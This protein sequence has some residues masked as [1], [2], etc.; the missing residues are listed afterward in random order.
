MLNSPLNRKLRMALIGGGGAGFIGKVHRTAAQL[1][2]RAEL[3]AGAFSSSLER[4]RESALAFGVDPSRAYASWEE[5]LVTEA[6]RPEDKRVDFVS[7]ATPNFLHFPMAQAALAAGFNVICDKPMTTKVADAETLV[8]LVEETGAVFALTHNYTG[9]PMVRQAK[10]M[11]ASGELGEIRAVR[12]NYVQGWMWAVDPE[13]PAARGNWKDD[14]LKNGPGAT[15]GDVGT[16]AYNLARYMTDLQPVEVLGKL[17]TFSGRQLDDYG[18]SLVR[19]SND[20]LIMVTVSQVSHGRL[21]DLSIEIDGDKASLTWRQEEPNS[22]TLRQTGQPQR[23]YDRAPGQ[24][25]MNDSGNAACRIPAGHPEAFFEAFANVY[26][27]AYDD[28]IWRA[29]GGD[30]D[31][32]STIY[33]NVY[34]G[35]EG[36]R[37]IEQTVASSNANSVWLPMSASAG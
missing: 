6:A 13:K 27:A 29:G 18:H 30:R 16:H 12:A 8:R 11:I 3:V 26:S 23:I 15:I 2:G 14:P 17:T 22:L 32:R 1:D 35:L 7:I 31:P 19:C 25:Y 33:P 36:V 28:M 21:N 4:S 9:Y 10:E 37:F 5:M 24:S 34:D 20:A